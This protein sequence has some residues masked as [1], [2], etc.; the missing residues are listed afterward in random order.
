MFIDSHAHLFDRKFESD[1]DR[2]LERARTAGVER[3]V[4]LG[5]T[6]ENSKRAIALALRHPMILAAAGVHPHHARSWNGTTEEELRRFTETPRVVAIGEIG[7]DYH[8]NP[9]SA[10]IQ[11]EVF[12]RQLALAREVGLPVSIH[13][14]DAYDDLI[15]DLEAEEGH[16]VGGILHCFTGNLA[17]A[18]KLI[19][20]GFYLGVGGTITFP[21]AEPLRNVI[22]ETGIDFVVLETDSPYLAPQAKRGRRNEPAHLAY[23]ARALADLTQHGYRD[24]ARTTRYNTL[25]ALRL[26]R[27]LDPQ[28]V[29][30]W[31]GQIYIN[32]TNDC[33]NDCEF[34]HKQG[35]GVLRGVRLAFSEPPSEDYILECLEDETLETYDS[36]VFSGL[37][38]PT[39]RLKT[40]LRIAKAL[41]NKGKRITLETNGQADLHRETSVL[42]DLEGVVD[43]LRVSLNASNREAYNSLCHPEDPER[44]FDAVVSF[45]KHAKDRFPEV[46]ATSVDLPEIDLEAVRRLA[47][48]DIGVPLVVRE[49]ERVYGKECSSAS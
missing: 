32:I 13:C 45:L 4:T 25:R 28:T 17:D 6:I 9:D 39:M 49:Y 15:E 22:R 36:A 20:M 16:R 18:R 42:D 3:I 8:Y 14:R 33:T 24:I 7:L 11:R 5:D 48:D 35:E 31:E 34:C 21:N 30:V 27:D 44:A 1:L 23:T 12:R 19:E 29:Y 38:E 47:E 46:V 40:L 43:T 2:V 10:H 26:C 41:R 37:G